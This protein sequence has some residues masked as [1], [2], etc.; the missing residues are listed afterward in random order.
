[1]H[2]YLSRLEAEEEFKMK[3]M[4]CSVGFLQQ[5]IDNSKVRFYDD[6]KLGYASGVLMMRLPDNRRLPRKRGIKV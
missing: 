3:F 1:M 5:F 4:E 6:S 2:F